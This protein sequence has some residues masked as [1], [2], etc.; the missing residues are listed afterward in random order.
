[1]TWLGLLACTSLV[2]AQPTDPDRAA[3]E[4]FFDDFV[5]KTLRRTAFSPP[6]WEALGT[7]YRGYVTS[8]GL[9]E[10]FAAASTEAELW[11]A[12]H[13]LNASRRDRHLRVEGPRPPLQCI[14][15]RFYPDLGDERAPTFFVA[16]FD[17]EAEAKGVSRGDGLVAIDGVPVEERVEQL[18]DE[19]AYSTARNLYVRGLGNGGD[20]PGLLSCV[21]SEVSWS[22]RLTLR[23]AATG[24]SKTV[25]LPRTP[26]VPVA[27]W[28]QPLLPT[29]EGWRSRYAA[30]GFTPLVETPD[31]VLY[32]DASRRVAVLEWLQLSQVEK[33]LEAVLDA[34]EKH[35]ALG[36]GLVL[37]LTH[38]R[39]GSRSE[40]VVATVA[41]APFET[42]FGNVR[43]EDRAFVEA[44]LGQHAGKV[45]RWIRRALQA[46]APY[47]TNE[48]FK[49]RHFPAGSDGVMKPAKRRFTGPRA[50]LLFPWGGSNLDQ[51]A[52]M[53]VDNPG[54]GVHTMGMSAGGYSNTWEWSEA[55]EVPGLGPVTF[56]WTVGHTLRPNGE[57]LEGNPARAADWRPLTRDNAP[58]YLTDLLRAGIAHVSESP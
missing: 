56:M 30:L 52:A 7:D 27:W 18:W 5:D 44:H 10:R 38:G 46:G 12:V 29:R 24:A 37:D 9:R 41:D 36:Y 14:P 57:V 13:R 11:D 32:V 1:M 3:R 43:V 47:T 50:A 20:Y 48:P 39:G 55:L 17:A 4:A 34:A 54:V 53:L 2:D 31:A 33:T 40:L 45:R 42:T 51:L 15:V 8:R 28:H 23:D 19:A 49:L 25:E 26:P 6:K 22:T 16:N 21:R 58:T 35:D